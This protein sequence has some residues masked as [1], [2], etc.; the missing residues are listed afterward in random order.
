MLSS[1]CDVRNGERFIW[2]LQFWATLWTKKGDRFQ[3][4]LLLICDVQSSVVFCPLHLLPFCSLS[5]TRQY[6]KPLNKTNVLC[7]S[8][9]MVTGCINKVPVYISKHVKSGTKEGHFGVFRGHLRVLKG[10]WGVFKGHLRVFPIEPCVYVLELLVIAVNGD[11]LI[12]RIR[13]SEYKFK[14]LCRAKWWVDCVAGGDVSRQRRQNFFMSEPLSVKATRKP[15]TT[16]K[17]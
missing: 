8:S 1:C 17:E 15:L 3:L 4:F 9:S 6:D 13:I 14:E 12:C 11:S 10:H 2:V 7:L 16:R 5:A